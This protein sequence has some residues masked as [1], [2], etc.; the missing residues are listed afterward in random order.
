LLEVVMTW[1]KYLPRI[2]MQWLMKT[3]ENLSHE[4]QCHD[5]GLKLAHSEYKCKVLGLIQPPL[6]IVLS[7]IMTLQNLEGG[8]LVCILGVHRCLNIKGT[9]WGADW[10]PVKFHSSFC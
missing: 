3:M 7:C 9:C 6:L 10:W 2:C 1:S 4:G 8:H 5:W